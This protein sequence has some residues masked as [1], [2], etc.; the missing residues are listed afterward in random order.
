MG[1][2]SPSA[3]FGGLVLRAVIAPD[4]DVDVVPYSSASSVVS[5][6]GSLR[7][8]LYMRVDCGDKLC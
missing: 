8:D 1:V 4:L 5:R 6:L 7:R 2:L 3:A